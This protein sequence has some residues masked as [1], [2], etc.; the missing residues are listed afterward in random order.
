MTNMVAAVVGGV[1]PFGAI[2]VELFFVLSSIWTD[3][4]YYVY[5]F[6]LISFFILINTCAEV[7]IV[8]TY[9]QLCAEDYKWY[10]FN[11]KCACF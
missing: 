6:L 8:L 9:F 2:F 11:L 10:P 7:T 4:Y 3:K 1:L 5:G